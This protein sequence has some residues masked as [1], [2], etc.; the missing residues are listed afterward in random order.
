MATYKAEFMSHYYKRRMRPIPAYTM[1]LIDFWAG[2]GS[3]AP[4]L[5]NAVMRLPLMKTLGGIAKERSMPR[6]ASEAF[7]ERFMKRSGAAGSS[8][9]KATARR[10]V[11]LWPDTFNNHFLPDTAMA[12]VDVL[13]RAGFE[14]VIP[15]E[16][17]C[18]GRPLYDWGF[19][20]RA[21]KLLRRT[22]HGLRAELAEGLPIVGLEPSCVSVFRDELL[23]LLP[24]DANAQKLAGSVVTLSEL[25][26]REKV[27]L[28]SLPRKAIVQAHCHHKAVM[29]FDSEE[30]VLRG[31]GLD[32]QHPDS[33]CCGMA[34][35]FGF[36]RRHYELSMNIGN[37]VI[38]P[39][40]RDSDPET[41]IIANGFSCREQIEQATG[42][43]TL[44][45]A[46]VMRM[47]YES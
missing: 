27:P 26:E 37:R 33:G 31:I 32:L 20:G 35:A 3:K 17:L 45:F 19:L 18:C 36:E 12:A 23:N 44:H 9:P 8:P 41:L 24:Q 43:P 10:R 30:A 28:P 2:L 25:L 14:V 40:V 15:Q 16:R 4:S 39:L 1:G 47:A 22:L 21:K 42:R 6:F 46:E 11:V 5:A 13:E 7:R 38:L 34:G 29:R